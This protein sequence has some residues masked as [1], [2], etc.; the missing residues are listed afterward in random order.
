VIDEHELLREE[1]AAH[2]L[3]A[4]DGDARDRLEAHLAGC[5]ACRRLLAEYRQAADHLP[6]LLPVEP[7]P[8][9]AW[10]G[11]ERRIRDTLPATVAAA[12][13]TPAQ[14]ATRSGFWRRLTEG[15]GKPLLAAAAPVAALAVLLAVVIGIAPFVF[16]SSS[17]NNRANN[18]NFAAATAPA[19]AVPTLAA[20]VSSSA[21]IAAAGSAP[22]TSP[23]NASASAATQASGLPTV[24]AVGQPPAGTPPPAPAVAL[25]P[26]A[27]RAASGPIAAASATAP[28]L[29]TAAPAVAATPAAPPRPATPAP[30]TRAAAS[31]TAPAQAAPAQPALPAATPARTAVAVRTATPAAAPPSAPIARAATAVAAPSTTPATGDNLS[32]LTV[33]LAV[34]GLLLVLAGGLL[35]RRGFG[36]AE[37]SGARNRGQR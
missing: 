15:W 32:D 9:G 33:G 34:A 24:A 8:A 6:F 4:L 25:A 7:P 18:A 31:A 19:S 12:A 16:R 1:V 27:T 14:A 11:I 35:R 37:Q 28:A 10:H 26:S 23:A 22:A 13:A 29:A 3:G 36:G 21:T 17:I 20:A 30:P 2:A 5:A